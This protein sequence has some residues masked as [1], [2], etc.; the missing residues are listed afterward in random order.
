MLNDFIILLCVCNW[1]SP[2]DLPMKQFQ[3][4]WYGFH[5]K[6]WSLTLLSYW[7]C[8]CLSPVALSTKQFSNMWLE[9]YS[10]LCSLTFLSDCCCNCFS[11]VALPIKQF[12]TCWYELYIKFCSLTLLSY[13]VAIVINSCVTNDTSSKHLNM[14]FTSV[15]AQRLYH[16]TVRV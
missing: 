7:V 5:S 9:F 1:F 4:F 3:K 15:Y 13:G 11:A 8:N 6:F 12:Q 2:V 16:P 14:S 10:T